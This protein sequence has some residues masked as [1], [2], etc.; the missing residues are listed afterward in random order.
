MKKNRIFGYARDIAADNARKRVYVLTV[1]DTIDSIDY[2]GGNLIEVLS[3][4]TRGFR[5]L[6]IWTNLLYCSNIFSDHVVEFNV[7]NQTIQRFIP[8][9]KGSYP[10]DVVVVNT[11]VENYGKFSLSYF[12][13]I[14][15]M[16][17]IGYK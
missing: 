1:K 8:F 15:T 14:C 13:S 12:A 7:N 16:P 6:D 9:T 17:Y 4:P 2:N 10:S 5:T 3:K 11:S